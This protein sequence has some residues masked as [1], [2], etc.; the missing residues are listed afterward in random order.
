MVQNSGWSYFGFAVTLLEKIHF[1]F[2]QFSEKNSRII[3]YPLPLVAGDPLWERIDL[4]LKY[5]I[6]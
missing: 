6:W 1:S 4:P 2:L 3:G 5:E